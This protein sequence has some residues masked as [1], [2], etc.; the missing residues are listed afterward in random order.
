MDYSKTIRAFVS[1]L[2]LRNLS[3][4]EKLLAV[5]AHC[6]GGTTT[7]E[8]ATSD[9][10][11]SWPT[12][13]LGSAYHGTY[14]A[15]ADEAGW[16][17]R[18]KVGVIQVTQA[19]LDHLASLV[20]TSAAIQGS[21]GARLHVFDIKQTHDFDKFLRSAFS[22]ATTSVSVADAYVDDTIFDNLLDQIPVGVEIRL[23]HNKKQGSFDAR[24]VRFAT[25]YAKF[26][27]KAYVE[28][29]DRFLIVDGQGYVVGPSLKD[30]ARKSP[31]LLVS[32][33][34]ADSA[35]L[36]QFFEELWRRSM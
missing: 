27:T 35:K 24:V 14:F 5:A 17:S 18:V 31:A 3:G 1:S 7:R 34:A 20:G 36:Q 32:L 13:T 26:Q 30:A 11:K 10:K 12:S 4:Q 25:Q 16:F 6:A 23:I 33:S 9:I 2:P 29:H 21:A 8:V 19:G 22:S 28:L 15:R